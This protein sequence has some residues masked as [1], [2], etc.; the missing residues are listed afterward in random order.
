MECQPD[1]AGRECGPDGCDGQCGLCAAGSSCDASGHC[2]VGGGPTGNGDGQ[3]ESPC[4]AGQSMYYGVCLPEPGDNAAQTIIPLGEAD[5]GGANGACGVA[6]RGWAGGGP[7]V[8]TV[9]LVFA[10]LGLKRRTRAGR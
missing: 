9:L 7:M 8:L 6:S 2:A 3:A 4:P 10:L 1:C 5:G